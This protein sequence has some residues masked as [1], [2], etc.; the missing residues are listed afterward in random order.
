MGQ[1]GGGGG[2]VGGDG[3]LPIFGQG[4]VGQFF[5]SGLELCMGFPKPSVLIVFA[6]CHEQVVGFGDGFLAADR[7]A[8]GE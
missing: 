3:L 7:L 2:F 4:R 5:S 1:R 8:F 6:A